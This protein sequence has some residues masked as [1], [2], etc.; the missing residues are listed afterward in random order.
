MSTRHE[1][2]LVPI[3]RIREPENPSRLTIDPE[4]V[5]AL[6]ASLARLGLLEPIGL[7]TTDAGA[8][9][10]VIYGHR[11]LLAARFLGWYDIPALILP[12]GISHLEARQAENNQRVQLTPV[13]EARELAHWHDQGETIPTLAARVNRSANWVAAR[14]RLLKYP[15][16]ILTAIHSHGL[17]LTVA[18]LLAQIDHAGYRTHMTR[19]ALDNGASANTVA[20]WLAHYH[21]NHARLAANM[22]TVEEIA[23]HR[24]A[25]RI[26][27]PCEYC[28]DQTDLQMT[29]MWRLCA[30]CGA[31]LTAA[32]AAPPQEAPTH[33]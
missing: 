15:D 29:R 30:P 26:L 5:A 27:A 20:V 6:A 2:H 32:K 1:T 9:Y 23:A 16:D 8:T 4:A 24:D 33:V 14:L 10:T 17:P 21:A 22:D 13:E 31:G 18:D 7:S 28:G 25:Y 3:D 11:R 12:A 19:D